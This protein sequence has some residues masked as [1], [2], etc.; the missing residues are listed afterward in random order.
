MCKKNS[1]IKNLFC[2]LHK[3]GVMLFFLQKTLRFT[4]KSNVVGWAFDSA[5]ESLHQG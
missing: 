3:H 4:L 1:C 2:V 5:H